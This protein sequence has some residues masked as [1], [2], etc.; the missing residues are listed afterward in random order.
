MNVHPDYEKMCALREHFE[1]FYGSAYQDSGK[2]WTIGYGSTFNYNLNRKVQKGDKI[3]KIE[4]IRY[5]AIDTESVIKQLNYYIHVPLNAV[6]SAALVD[7]VYNR[8]IGNFLKTKLDELIN[9]NP[10]D[11]KIKNEFYGTGL[12]DRMGCKLWGL[13]R[14]RRTEWHLYST[15]VVKT[16]WVKWG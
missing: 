11:A 10:L 1:G 9:S 14:R 13:G 16:D 12:W 3:S 7:Y 6:Q 5:A 2:V 8:G 15:G 4:A